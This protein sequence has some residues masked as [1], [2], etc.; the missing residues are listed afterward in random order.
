VLLERRLT[1]GEDDAPRKTTAF[2]RLGVSDGDT[3]AFKGGWQA[4]VLVERVFASRADSAFSIGVNQ[5][6]CR[7]ST[8][9]TPSTLASA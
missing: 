6:F 7:A 1:G 3:T 4:G 5:A 9:T 8:A 2:A